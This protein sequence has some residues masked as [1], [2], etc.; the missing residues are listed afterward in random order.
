MTEFEREIEQTINRHSKENG[1]DTPDFILAAYLNDCLLAFNR[2][3]TWRGKWYSPEGVAES[4]RENGPK[5]EDDHDLEPFKMEA[6]L[7]ADKVF[8]HSGQRISFTSR[9]GYEVRGRQEILLFGKDTFAVKARFFG[10]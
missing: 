10:N 9:Q 3:V 2:A 5:A 4:E 6:E 8:Y 1:S 7:R